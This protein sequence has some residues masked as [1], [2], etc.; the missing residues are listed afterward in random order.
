MP[1]KGEDFVWGN[2]GKKEA[3]EPDNTPI[4]TL[5]YAITRMLRAGY[6]ENQMIGPLYNKFQE[7][8]NT[9]TEVIHSYIK[10]TKSLINK[11][12][13][14]NPNDYDLQSNY[15]SALLKLDP[16]VTSRMGDDWI[17]KLKELFGVS[18]FTELKSKYDVSEV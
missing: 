12:N 5:M 14:L 15:K 6:K 2:V 17:K 4:E 3:P 13:G 18:T 11:A 7:N 1:D 10:I 16:L 9:T 8:S